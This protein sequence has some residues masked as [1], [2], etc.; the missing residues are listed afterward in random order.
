M[1]NDFHIHYIP[2][3][4]GRHTAFFKG[5][6]NDKQALLRFLGENNIAKAHIVFPST[7]AQDKL[8]WPNLVKEYNQQM[9]ALMQ[10]FPGRIFCSGIVNLDSAPDEGF[11]KELKQQ[12]FKSISLPSSYKGRF[13]V[14]KLKFKMVRQ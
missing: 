12:G 3:N 7:D 11:L 8:G 4:I 6:W 5:L 2:E 9:L 13:I 14:E 1:V 10:E